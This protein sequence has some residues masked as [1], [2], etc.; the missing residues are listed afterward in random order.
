VK[1][2]GNQINKFVLSS[3]WHSSSASITI[4]KCLPGSGMFVNGCLKSI[5]NNPSI[6][7]LSNICPTA[8]V[9]FI[10]WKDITQLPC[11][12]LKEKLWIIVPA[13][14]ILEKMTTCKMFWETFTC[15]RNDHRL[16]HS[17]LTRN[18]EC[19]I[20]RSCVLQPR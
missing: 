7:R 2:S 10:F 9:L 3:C 1:M 18:D 17:S 15:N 13:I 5:V 4:R 8:K 12:R 16:T 6:F 19:T 20:I 14:I 11:Q